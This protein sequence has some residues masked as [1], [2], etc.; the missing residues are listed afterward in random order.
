MSLRGI[1]LGTLAGA[2]EFASNV[3]LP[4]NLLYT[5]EEGVCHEALG[6]SKGLAPDADVSANVKLL[7]MLAGLGSPGTIQEV[8]GA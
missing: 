3:G 2:K 8:G 4:E 1:G 6:L 7:G 5:D